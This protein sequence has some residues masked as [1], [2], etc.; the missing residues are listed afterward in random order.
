MMMLRDL[1]AL[2]FLAGLGIIAFLIWA[3]IIVFWIWMIV[4]CAQRRFR[5]TPEKIIW[6]IVIVLGWWV[7]SLVYFLVIRMYNPHGLAE[8]PAETLRQRRR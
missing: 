5:N 7:G 2:P 3:L 6:L 4:D 1:W 8:A